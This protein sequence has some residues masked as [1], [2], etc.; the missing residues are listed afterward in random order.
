MVVPPRETGGG[1][2]A[3]AA[4]AGTPAR[5]RRVPPRHVE[6]RGAIVGAAAWA[7]ARGRP[8]RPLWPDAPPQQ[9]SAR[10]R[11]SGEFKSFW[12]LKLTLM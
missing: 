11:I 7:G 4:R 10:M 3:V 8:A 2:A 12:H 6:V 1:S 5:E 9:N